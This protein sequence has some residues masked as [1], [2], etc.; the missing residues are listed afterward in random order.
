MKFS[1]PGR[2]V[3]SARH[4]KLNIVTPVSVVNVIGKSEQDI[5]PPDTKTSSNTSTATTSFTTTTTE[6]TTKESITTEKTTTESTATESTTTKKTTTKITTSESTT[7]QTTT[8]PQTG[9]P[10]DYNAIAFLA[11]MVTFGG[12]VIVIRNRKEG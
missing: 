3:I 5:T 6:S 4:D 10:L 12:A 11:F 2:N 7:T 9:Y 1:E 8:L